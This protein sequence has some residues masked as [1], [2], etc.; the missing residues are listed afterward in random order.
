LRKKPE[1]SLDFNDA[2]VFGELIHLLKHKGLPIPIMDLLIGAIA[3]SK[4]LILI[5]TDQNHFD[6]L[7]DV[8]ENFKVEYW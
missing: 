4:N 6:V 5:S 3:Y 1:I 2:K 7:K 8:K